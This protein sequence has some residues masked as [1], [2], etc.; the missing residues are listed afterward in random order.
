ML[1]QRQLK[2]RA[3]DTSELVRQHQQLQVEVAK[4]AEEAEEHR[5]AREKLRRE[6]EAVKDASKRDEAP[7]ERY[8]SALR[9]D[10]PESN[11][12]LS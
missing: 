6:L 10:V 9:L 8:L 12:V 3:V 11:I 7:A 1:V 4:K 2:E 5:L